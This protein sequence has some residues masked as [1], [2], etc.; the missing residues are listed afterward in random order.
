MGPGGMAPSTARVWGSNIPVRSLGH[1]FKRGATV[2]RPRGP[3][4]GLTV[5]ARR[6]GGG[7]E[8]S[9]VCL[10]PG[11][12]RPCRAQRRGLQAGGPREATALPRLDP[13]PGRAQAAELS[14][15][16]W[17]RR[18]R[19]WGPTQQAG[20]PAL[21]CR[22]GPVGEPGR[23]GSP[24][25]WLSPFPPPLLPWS[26]QAPQFRVPPGPESSPTSGTAGSHVVLI[27]RRTTGQA[28]SC[29]AQPHVSELQHQLRHLA[30][31]RLSVLSQG[32]A[33]NSEARRAGSAPTVPHLGAHTLPA[34]P[35]GSCLLSSTVPLNAVPSLH[36][37]TPTFQPEQRDPCEERS[38][39]R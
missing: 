15:Q 27:Q 33:A 31:D 34:R 2:Q 18:R 39:G 17:R 26:V 16:V 1:F 35:A 25:S 13:W 14:M 19:C 20:T 5:E 36:P 29:L 23:G 32:R 30:G 4:G 38:L 21:G 37:L 12:A 24:D 11:T 10:W 22:W 8:G 3:Q 28:L 9:P 6:W 7:G